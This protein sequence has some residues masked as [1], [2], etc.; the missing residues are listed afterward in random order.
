[1]TEKHGT[2]TSNVSTVCREFWNKRNRGCPRCP[3]VGPCHRGESSEG[4]DEA[5]CLM[6]CKLA[7]AYLDS[8][9]DG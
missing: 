4:L 9:K 5:D 2:V 1:M 7:D 6:M 8:E 3:M